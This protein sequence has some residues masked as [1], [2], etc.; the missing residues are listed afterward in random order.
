MDVPSSH[1]Q[2]VA[3]IATNENQHVS[4]AMHYVLGVTNHKKSVT[5]FRVVNFDEQS[6]RTILEHGLSDKSR[7]FLGTGD[8]F[9]SQ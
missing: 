6:M 3:F 1:Q 7:P 2:G 9:G 5:V 4:S 8:T